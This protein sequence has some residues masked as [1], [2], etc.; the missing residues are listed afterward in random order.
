[1]RTPGKAFGLSGVSEVTGVPVTCSHRFPLVPVPYA[2]EPQADES[3][4]VGH[5]R[6]P[7]SV[8]CH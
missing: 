8:S 1:M 4:A 3:C 2:H 7:W 6:Q 5:F